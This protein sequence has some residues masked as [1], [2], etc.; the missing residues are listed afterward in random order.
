MFVVIAYRWGNREN[1]SYTLGCFDNIEDAKSC[2]DS[3]AS[4]RAAKYG[5]VV[6]KCVLNHFDDD[7]DDY[8]EE[9]YRTRSF[10]DEVI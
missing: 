10:M 6:E 4:Y 3:H 7:S 1:H 2:A 5:C 9:V 8:T